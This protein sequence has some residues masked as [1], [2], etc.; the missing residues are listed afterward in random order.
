MATSLKRTLLGFALAALAGCGKV[1]PLVQAA[2]TEARPD[3]GASAGAGGAVSA[4]DPLQSSRPLPGPE[5]AQPADAGSVPGSP[6]PAPIA[7]TPGP[8]S[9]KLSLVTWNTYGLPAPIG[10]DLK[11]RFSAMPG[12]LH[13]FD[14]VALQETFDGAAKGLLSH[15]LYPYSHR[16]ESTEF[17]RMNPGLT[18]L[19]RHRIVETA[20]R[21]FK[22][23]GDTD[24]LAQKGVLFARLDVAGFG[25]VDIYDTHYQ[26]HG[27]Y[28]KER[29]HD[30]SVLQAMV[31]E[32]D[33]GHPTFLLGDFN[34]RE[35]G[36]EYVDLMNRLGPKDLYR[37]HRPTEKGGTS[38]SGSRIDYVF[39]VPARDYDVTVV[40]SAVMFSGTGLSDHNGVRVDVQITA[41]R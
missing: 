25:P 22:E 29:L 28:T 19:S 7:P 20:F 36:T 1:A 37:L 21:P 12:V 18:M 34:L 32:H 26:A 13:G 6:G 9:V 31:N 35:G 24:C 17:L 3:A 41:R 4:G 38:K 8:R 15:T 10:T 33:A 5:E 2:G 23:C 11:K 14:V 16:Q 39:C 40:D 30:N 27:P